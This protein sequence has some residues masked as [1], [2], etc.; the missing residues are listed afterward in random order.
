MFEPLGKGARQT[1]KEITFQFD[2][3]VE[4][5]IKFKLQQKRKFNYT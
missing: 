5:I 2:I 3:G 1:V 4:T